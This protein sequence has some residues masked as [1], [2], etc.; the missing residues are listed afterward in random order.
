MQVSYANDLDT[1]EESSPGACTIHSCT[2]W[3][4]GIISD[5]FISDV[6]LWIG[7]ITFC[8][9][10][11]VI[12]LFNLKWWNWLLITKSQQLKKKYVMYICRKIC[13]EKYQ[14]VLS[15]YGNLLTYISYCFIKI[16]I[17]NW[18]ARF[19]NLQLVGEKWPNSPNKFIYMSMTYRYSVMGIIGLRHE[20]STFTGRQPC[21]YLRG[22]GWREGGLTLS[23]STCS[24][25]LN[26]VCPIYL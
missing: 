20:V 6:F 11:N 15:Y 26:C 4:Y 1:L 8:F 23:S 7:D 24:F 13:M 21:W 5:L 18:I 10:L 14:R 19:K 3:G 22:G 16:K 25:N 17:L 12:T 2:L 9:L